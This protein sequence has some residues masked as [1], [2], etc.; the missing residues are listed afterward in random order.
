MKTKRGIRRGYRRE[1]R[2]GAVPWVVSVAETAPAPPV[3][4]AADGCTN[5]FTPRRGR[6]R[7]RLYCDECREPLMYNRRWR[8]GETH[9]GPPGPPRVKVL[10]REQVCKGCGET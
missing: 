3:V 10:P 1:R 7:P 2:I 6:G 8:A 9:A 5:T 4:C